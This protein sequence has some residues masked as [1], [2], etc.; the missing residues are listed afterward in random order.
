MSA[1]LRLRQDSDE[2][3]AEGP[4]IAEQRAGA[5]PIASWLDVLTRMLPARQGAEVREELEEHVR[6]RVRDLVLA[7]QNEAAATRTTIAE[8]GDAAAVAQRFRDAARTPKR[9]LAMNLAVLGVAG[10]ALVT[11]LVGVMRPVTGTG[12][13]VY[14]PIVAE[15]VPGGKEPGVPALDLNDLGLEEALSALAKSAG[16][17]LSV[18]WSSLGGGGLEPETRITWNVPAGSLSGAFDALNDALARDIGGERLIDF[19]LRESVLEVARPEWF[20]H[21]ESTLVRY[22]LGPLEEQGV[23]LGEFMGLVEQ[24]VS[25]D[26]W[27]NNGGALAK[28]R[29]VGRFAFVK[30]PPRIH[31][32]VRWF[33]T[34][35]TEDDPPDG[36]PAAAADGEPV[37]VY[38]IQHTDAQDLLKVLMNMESIRE[39]D[40][41]P[42]ASDPRTNSILGR[43]PVKHHD[44]VARAIRDL[45]NPE[46]ALERRVGEK[47]AEMQHMTAQMLAQCRDE[48][49]RIEEEI[50]GL[51][52][53]GVGEDHPDAEGLRQRLKEAEARE[54]E[55]RARLQMLEQDAGA[56]DRRGA[57]EPAPDR[58]TVTATAEARER[59][60]T[61]FITGALVRPME[62]EALVTD[63]LRPA[64][65]RVDL[66]PVVRAQTYIA[67][68]PIIRLA[69]APEPITR[70]LLMA[71]TEAGV[72]AGMLRSMVDRAGE[73]VLGIEVDE[74][75]NTVVLRGPK[76]QVLAAEEVAWKL[77][78]LAGVLPARPE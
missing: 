26:D 51:A 36:D 29:V 43:A 50:K 61:D 69:L 39:V 4:R 13:Q 11:S 2:P 57:A 33:L 8:L 71:H 52:E 25:S 3:R 7:G 74:A 19:R 65:V 64:M 16:A 18:R 21:R 73:P 15:R 24:F 75:H 45:D 59:A 53:R 49:A 32:G 76:D 41:T 37:R 60:L 22:D 46:A 48:R 70:A 67:L 62:T 28:H 5:D 42:W 9:R 27:E 1:P 38:H 40:F 20:D 35:F 63:V 68:E 66:E 10:A 72:V 58:V 44:L 12:G 31:D 23:P 47:N 6:E 30:G 17:A 14:Q 77:D 78:H 55:A 56:P 34:Q 54:A